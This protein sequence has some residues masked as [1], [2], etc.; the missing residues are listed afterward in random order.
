MIKRQRRF[1]LVIESSPSLCQTHGLRRF[2][3]EIEGV[4]AL[5]IVFGLT[6]FARVCFPRAGCD[7]AFAQPFR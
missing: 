4:T 2:V 6:A 5:S 7:F 1:E 3:S